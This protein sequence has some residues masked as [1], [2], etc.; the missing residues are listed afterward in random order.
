MFCR[1]AGK[2]ERT[3]RSSLVDLAQVNILT[4]DKHR[5][6]SLELVVSVCFCSLGHC[7]NTI[8]KLKLAV[9]LVSLGLCND[10]WEQ[11]GSCSGSQGTGALQY[12]SHLGSRASHASPLPS[13][14][15]SAAEH[16]RLCLL[17]RLTNLEWA[18]RRRQMIRGVPFMS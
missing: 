7:N 1:R 8:E 11:L 4:H 18:C 15:A 16:C 17:P 2:K 5:K 10:S 9:T 12:R 14:V 13:P 6:Q 3:S